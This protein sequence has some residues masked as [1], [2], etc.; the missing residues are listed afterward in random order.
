MGE[1]GV[2]ANQ[3]R[4]LAEKMA[5]PPGAPIYRVSSEYVR[6]RIRQ[7]EETSRQAGAWRPS[8]R[9]GATCLLE[10]TSVLMYALELPDWWPEWAT[11]PARMPSP[12]SVA[13]S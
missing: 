4:R 9:S 3:V 8:T 2:S 6:W 13:F 12:C 11:W 7:G 5:L 1:A 10:R